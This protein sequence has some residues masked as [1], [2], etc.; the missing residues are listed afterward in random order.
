MRGE[1]IRLHATVESPRRCVPQVGSL[2]W[3]YVA[4]IV[5]LMTTSNKK[6]KMDGKEAK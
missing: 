5:L 6:T 4:I 3:A 2:R 1:R